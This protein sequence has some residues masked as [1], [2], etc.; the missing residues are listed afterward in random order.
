MGG[1]GKI[2]SQKFYYKLSLLLL[3]KK[4]KKGFYLFLLFRAAPAAYGR[5]QARGRIGATPASL[6]H[7]HSHTGSEGICDLRQRQI[8]GPLREPGTEPTSSWILVGFI[9]TAPQWELP[10]ETFNDMNIVR[11]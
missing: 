8:S 6:H 9:S 1:E 11:I 7:N 5:S 3:R 4:K 2:V 10:R